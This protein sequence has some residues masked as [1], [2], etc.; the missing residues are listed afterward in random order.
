MNRTKCELIADIL[1]TTKKEN[2]KTRIRYNANLTDN[3]F[4][5]YLVLLLTKNLL[6]LAQIDGK[7]Y[8]KTTAKGLN[9]L[10]KYQKLNNFF[11]K[12]LQ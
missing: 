4:K 3:Q 10:M 5:G 11:E 8:Y 6:T 1:L 2:L 12:T 9:F 7:T